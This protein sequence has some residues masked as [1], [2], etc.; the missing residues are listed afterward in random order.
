MNA[1]LAKSFFL[2][3]GFCLLQAC[4]VKSPLRQDK[5]ETFSAV[6]VEGDQTKALPDPQ[7]NI[8]FVVDN[9]G[10]MKPHQ[11]KMAANIELFANEFFDNAR[12]DYRIGV[13]PVYDQRYLND[14]K[15]YRSGYR[16]MNSLGELVPLKGS[17]DVG[18]QLYITRDTPN[19]KEVLKSTVLIGVQCGPEAEESFSPVLAVTDPANNRKNQDFYIADAHLA[20]IFL[21]DADDATLTFSGAELYKRLVNLKKG[22]Q[23]KVL[24]AA[25]LPNLRN[26]SDNC[27]KDGSGPIQAFSDLLSA[28]GG[29][30]A[31]LCSDN[32][33]EELASFGKLIKNR[34]TTQ[35]IALGSTPD[36]NSLVV[37]YGSKDQP[38]SERQVLSRE[39]VEYYFLPETNE[40]MLNPNAKLQRVPNAKIWVTF[41]P[42]SLGNAKNGRLNTI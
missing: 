20:V 2:L 24:I 1:K 23:S 41:K 22:D 36:I 19:P 5:A 35:K 6:T 21:T 13:V 25:A 16:K 9:S 17:P 40:V 4:D 15:E 38:E 33:G 3:G 32:F 10:S 18:Q 11:D 39:K 29:I 26:K 34:V 28:S 31:D 37:S 8:L 12:L 30:L 14:K 27:T 7:I 42:A